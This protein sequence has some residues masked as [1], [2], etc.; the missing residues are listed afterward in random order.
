M[1]IA[2]MEPADYKPTKSE[3]AAI[4]K[5]EAAIARGDSVSLTEFLNGLD[6]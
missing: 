3:W 4:R 2:A 5:G 6:T 1:T